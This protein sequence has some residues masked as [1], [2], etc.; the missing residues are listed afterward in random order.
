[1]KNK[2][3]NI[4]YVNNSY[5][6]NFNMIFSIFKYFKINYDEEKNIYSTIKENKETLNHLN[7]YL[8][9]N[10]ELFL[11]KNLLNL[12]KIEEKDIFLKCLLEN[13]N[14]KIEIQKEIISKL[15]RKIEIDNKNLK[16]EIQQLLFE[17]NIIKFKWINILNYFNNNLNVEEKKKL[18]FY[19]NNSEI[20]DLLKNISEEKTSEFTEY[21]LSCSL[22]EKVFEK[23]FENY[24]SPIR[25]NFDKI[26][27][28][29][30][31]VL[32]KNNCIEFKEDYSANDEIINKIK[33]RELNLHI[34]YIINNIESIID[35]LNEYSFE[36]E[37]Y[38]LL[39]TSNKLED[40]KKLLIIKKLDF[41][42]WENLNIDMCNKILELN[43]TTNILTKEQVLKI[44]DTNNIDLILV[45]KNMS[46][47]KILIEDISLIENNLESIVTLEESNCISKNKENIKYIFSIFKS[48]EPKFLIKYLNN[49]I[50]WEG[51][52][53]L[54][55]LTYDKCEE[56]TDF[57]LKNNTINDDPFKYLIMSSTFYLNISFDQITFDR[58]KILIENNCIEFKEDDYT[59]TLEVINCL[60]NNDSKLYLN[61]IINNLEIFIENIE[62]Y[63]LENKDYFLLLKDEKTTE[64][65]K[66]KI[67]NVIDYFNLTLQQGDSILDEWLVLDNNWSEDNII[68]IFKI[69]GI[70]I[71]KIEEFILKNNFKMKNIEEIKKNK[72]ILSLMINND[73]IIHSWENIIKLFEEI[74]LTDLINY[75][76]NYIEISKLGKWVIND[77]LVKSSIE[78][79]KNIFYSS[80]IKNNI[81][82]EIVFEYFE[83]IDEYVELRMEKVNRD[84][85]YFLI[86]NDFLQFMKKRNKTNKKVIDILKENSSFLI[87]YILNDFTFFLENINK[88]NLSAKEYNAILESN[89]FE[90]D[91][92]M[93]IIKKINL[94]N[95]DLKNKDLV[96]NILKYWLNITDLNEKRKEILKML[97]TDILSYVNLTSFNAHILLK[98]LNNNL[99]NE[100]IKILINSSEVNL[101]IFKKF[102]ENIPFE[103]S[104]KN[105]KINNEKLNILLNK[106]KILLDEYEVNKLKKLKKVI[107]LKYFIYYIKYSINDIQDIPLKN[108]YYYCLLSSSELTL[109]N[110]KL[111]IEYYCNN[112][113]GKIYFKLKKKFI[114]FYKENNFLLE[115]KIINKLEF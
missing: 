79:I 10:I 46:V 52:N 93:K 45:K 58:L 63:P 48:K 105:I 99:I 66:I 24:S 1:M 97:D 106:K 22:E 33:N 60:K 31:K 100:F 90:N 30:L 61:Y 82:E 14:I 70:N 69:N 2:Y 36:Q 13:Q 8:E 27:L 89:L 34:D 84:K 68:E 40:E 5:D 42:D 114:D 51:L 47:N 41:S 18:V 38:K 7:D 71:N 55:E 54:K 37:D 57:I 49:I 3:F 15:D 111:I 110:K 109:E 25:I 72:I 43:L 92:E 76:N 104:I 20:N 87:S 9:D 17:K 74:K 35:Q 83:E 96:I 65:M 59:Y 39:L 94:E 75:L 85:I 73:K 102:I 80:K 50:N 64:V 62:K 115:D 98:S 95:K 19:I 4:L 21:L 108:S 113:K 107:K 29:K 44:L 88:Y 12:N 26:D 56:F 86:K 32:I 53:V 6:L 91:Q 101:D 77:R 28:K 67:L 103:I 81:F 11:E 112:F 16:K 23:I 78:F